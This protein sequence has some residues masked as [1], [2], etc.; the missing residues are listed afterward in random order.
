M[1]TVVDSS[2]TPSQVGDD[3]LQVVRL[4]K[5]LAWELRP[6][7]SL[8]EN[9]TLDSYWRSLS[10]DMKLRYVAA[11]EMTV[12][13]LIMEIDREKALANVTRTWLQGVIEP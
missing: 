7:M 4:A 1:L 12:K 13:G 6:D 9:D 11:V 5:N 2:F 3:S 10:R 8:F